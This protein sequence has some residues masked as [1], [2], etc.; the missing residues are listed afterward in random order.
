MSKIDPGSELLQ[1][2]DEESENKAIGFSPLFSA[3]EFAR[4]SLPTIGVI[5]LLFFLLKSLT[6][7]AWKLRR[8]AK[9]RSWKLYCA[10]SA[11]LADSGLVRRYG[12]TRL[13]YAKRVDNAFLPFGE[14]SAT[15]NL[16]KYADRG[17]QNSLTTEQVNSCYEKFRLAYQRRYRWYQRAL[18]FINPASLL[19]R[20]W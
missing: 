18:H 15:I 16:I 7:H 3:K 4:A 1:E 10:I 8:T 2:F 14:I 12:E 20:K 11:R 13:E 19:R 5:A 17:S 6:Y 9:V